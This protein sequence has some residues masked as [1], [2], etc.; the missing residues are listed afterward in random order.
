MSD[1]VILAAVAAIFIAGLG[2]RA[3]L[4]TSAGREHV[5]HVNAGNAVPDSCL[6]H[7]GLRWHR[8]NCPITP[9]RTAAI[10]MLQNVPEIARLQCVMEQEM[11][12]RHKSEQLGNFKVCELIDNQLQSLA[13]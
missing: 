7:A 3:Y 2:L 4:R 12:L 6:L 10:E 11:I 9:Q 8:A 13:K 1:K 5:Q